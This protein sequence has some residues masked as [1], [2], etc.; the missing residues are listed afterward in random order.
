MPT[1]L[2]LGLLALTL[3][4]MLLSLL[5]L[6]PSFLTP[7]ALSTATIWIDKTVYVG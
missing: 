3:L 4:W 5:S 1:A 7:W 6:V 2:P